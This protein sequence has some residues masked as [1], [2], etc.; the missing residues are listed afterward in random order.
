MLN[1]VKHLYSQRFFATLR[2]TG[3]YCT[4]VVCIPIVIAR[5][6]LL[7]RSNLLSVRNGGDCLAPLAMTDPSGPFCRGHMTAITNPVA[8]Y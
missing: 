7:R 4:K 8:H 1:G 5:S 6:A 2:M 3:A